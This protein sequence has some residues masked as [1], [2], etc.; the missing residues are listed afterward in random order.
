MTKS[1][2]RRLAACLG[3]WLL[4]ASSS[5]LSPPA[6]AAPDEIA[7]RIRNASQQ[8]LRCVTLLAHFITRDL[9]TLQPDDSVS[10]VLGRDPDDGSLSYGRHGDK[11]ML[12]ENLLC[13]QVADW[14]ASRQDIPLQTLRATAAESYSIVCRGGGDALA[15]AAPTSP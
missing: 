7:L 9:P 8:P 6:S 4:T 3:F 11:P 12:I 15:C 1:T 5:L 10:I 13:G 2:M 14:S